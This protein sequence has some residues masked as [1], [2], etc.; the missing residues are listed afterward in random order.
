MAL[1]C[2]GDKR[3]L[4]NQMRQLDENDDEEG[5][6][7]AWLNKNGVKVKNDLSPVLTELNVSCVLD[8][9]SLNEAG[10]ENVVSAMKK[11]IQRKWTKNKISSK[12]ASLLTAA[13][14]EANS[15]STVEEW[16][17]ALSLESSSGAALWLME[18]GYEDELADL[19]EM[20]KEEQQ[21]FLSAARENGGEAQALRVKQALAAL[22]GISVNNLLVEL[23]VEVAEDTGRRKLCFSYRSIDVARVREAKLGLEA[24]GYQVA[25]GLDVDTMS[26]Q[27]WRTQWIHMCN[28]ADL[29]VNFLSVDYVQ[30]QACIDEWNYASKKKSGSSVLNLMLGGRHSREAIMK[31]TDAG[32]LDGLK[33]SGALVMHFTS[34]GQALSVY[35]NDDIVDKIAANL[36]DE[37]ADGTIELVG[38]SAGETK[39]DSTIAAATTV[40]LIGL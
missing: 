28:D 3:Y 35:P 5:C 24:M 18:E 1:P 14:T 25:W 27:D 32:K 12:L 37:V 20:E 23:L 22:T 6:E 26:T 8:L 31:L 17:E 38:G 16:L 9:A 2:V 7:M 15:K 34:D 21:M 13:I 30:S 10:L 19:K 36:P 33:G 39:S 29:V 40:S 4:E 11:P